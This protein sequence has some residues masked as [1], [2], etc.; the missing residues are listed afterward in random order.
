LIKVVLDTNI[1]I[2]G[3]LFAGK[4]REVLDLA[5]KG[6]I[7]VFISPDILS[8]L[9]DV[10]SIKKFCFSP[11][12]VDIIIREIESI[13]TMVNPAK[14]YSIVS[15]DSDDNIIIDCAMESRVEYIITGDNDL[16]CLN[17]YKSITIINPALFIEEYLDRRLTSE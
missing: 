14:K 16:L 9:R 1:Y 10:L 11:E 12:R 7:H 17:K 2:S 13:T 3:I 6:K 4:P 15:H 8:E 5:I